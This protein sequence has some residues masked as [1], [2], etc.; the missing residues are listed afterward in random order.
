M[1]YYL[2]Y[3][4]HSNC[5]EKRITEEDEEYILEI[6]IYGLNKKTILD[7]QSYTTK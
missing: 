1:F 4:F 2:Y 5:F 6:D 3:C 7:I